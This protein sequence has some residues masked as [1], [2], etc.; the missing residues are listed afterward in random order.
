MNE[1][2][3]ALDPWRAVRADVESAAQDNTVSVG[4]R[5]ARLRLFRDDLNDL[6]GRI[7][8]YLGDLALI[9]PE[10]KHRQR[11]L[12]DVVRDV[13]NEWAERGTP[14]AVPPDAL[15]DDRE[16]WDEVTRR[17]RLEGHT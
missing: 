11:S 9:E 16:F 8:S 10:A 4:A 13:A 17:A 15:D 6:L 12:S 2:W 1:E 7:D 14:L 3:R 5:V